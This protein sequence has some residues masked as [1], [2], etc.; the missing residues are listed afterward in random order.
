MGDRFP[1]VPSAL[2]LDLDGTLVNSE[3][4]HRAAYRSFFASRG[5]PSDDATLSLF[6]GRRADDVFANVAG[7]WSGESPTGLFE[8][9]LELVDPDR[10]PEPVPG[11]T[12][13]VRAAVAAG[14]PL[15]IVTSA[16]TAWVEATV[17]R[18][19]GIHHHFD[20]VITRDDVT[21]GKP[22]PACY[23]LAC[24]RLGADPAEAVAVEDAPAGVR[25][26]VAAGVGRVYGVTT[27]WGPDELLDAGVTDVVPDLTPLVELFDTGR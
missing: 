22:D 21:D 14:V 2:L 12:E 11:G 26:A 1:V 18:L 13:V 9:V 24:E 10:S 5:W 19:L 16:N 15:A 25:A 4:V 17:D 23:R 8:A 6:T 3:P 7:P 20:V 27:T